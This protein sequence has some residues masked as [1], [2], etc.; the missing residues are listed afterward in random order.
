MIIDSGRLEYLSLLLSTG[1]ERSV[2]IPD[3]EECVLGCDEENLGVGM[4]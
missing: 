3:I 1:E 4:R 2:N